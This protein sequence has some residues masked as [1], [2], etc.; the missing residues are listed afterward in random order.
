MR[1]FRLFI[2]LIVLYVVFDHVPGTRLAL[3]KAFVTCLQTGKSLDSFGAT[4]SSP[5]S[6]LHLPIAIHSLFGDA[7]EAPAE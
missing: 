4:I 3:K 1:L 2:P 6:Q 5:S 7:M